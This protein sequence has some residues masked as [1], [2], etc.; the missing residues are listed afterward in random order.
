MTEY[1]VGRD[2]VKR[3]SWKEI[4]EMKNNMKKVQ[5]VKEK[6][7]VYHKKEM[8]NLDQLLENIEE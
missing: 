1:Y 3:L 5:H 8:K 4:Q 7:Q 2:R 6:S